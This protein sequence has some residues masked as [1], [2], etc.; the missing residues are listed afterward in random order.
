[1]TLKNSSLWWHG[2]SW[3]FELRIPD[4][5]KLTK[6]GSERKKNAV[7]N[8][9]Q[10]VKPTLDALVDLE[11]F[12]SLQKCTR[13]LCYVAFFDH[14]KQKHPEY[15]SYDHPTSLTNR[16]NA[17]LRLIRNEQTKFFSDELRA[18]NAGESVAKKSHL[19]RLYP[20]VDDGL[21]KVGGRLTQNKNLAQPNR[22]T[23]EKST[24]QTH[25]AGHSS[26]VFSCSRKYD[27]C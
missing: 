12:S 9:S 19:L 24:G 3:L 7:V 11:T 27:P 17:L 5:P 15:G 13:V 22:Y 26:E 6:V 18:L 10:L 21:I 4:Q 14:R 1:M 20:F 2:P 25:P 23:Q 16:R 8:S